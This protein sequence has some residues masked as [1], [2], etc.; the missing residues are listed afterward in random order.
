MFFTYIIQS[1]VNGRDYTGSTANLNDRLKRHQEDRSKATKGKGPWKL[2][3]S[4]SFRTRSEAIK[5]EF[6]IKKKGA[7]RFL[8]DM[9]GS[10]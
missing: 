8:Q 10:G 9:N 4:D 2:V 3:Y 1:H 5:R 6:Q 7:R